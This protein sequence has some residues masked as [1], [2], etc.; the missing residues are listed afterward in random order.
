MASFFSASKVI[1]FVTFTVYVLL[2]NPISASRV[3]V[4]VGLYSAIRLTVTLFFPYAIERLS[5]ALVSIR[6]IQV[7]CRSEEAPGC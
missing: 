1:V 2:G 6:R 5:E 3:F 4:A 7:R